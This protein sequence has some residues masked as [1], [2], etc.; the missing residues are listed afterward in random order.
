MSSS[1]D[2]IT[3]L[4]SAQTY[5]YQVGCPILMFIG[6]LGCVLNL[7][8]FTQKNLR[9]NPCSIYFIT[10]NLSNFVYIYSSL[11]SLTLSVGYNIDPSAY[12]LAICH[13]RLYII[14]LFNCLSPFYLILASID[15]I[16]ITSPNARTRRRSTPHFAC[17]C[18]IFGTL[19]WVLFHSHA[20]ILTNITQLGPNYFLC[21]FQSGI[22]LVFIS[23]YSFIKELLAI[24]LMILCGLWS[25]KNIQNTH[26]VR[27]APDLSVSRTGIESNLHSTSSKDR[28][29]MFMLLLDTTIYGLF[30]FMFA[31]FL[32]YQQ[33]T[34]NYIKSAD[35]IQIENIIRN[36]CL[37]GVGVPFCSSCYT[38]LIASKTFRKKVKKVFSWKR[39]FCIN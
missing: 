18:I 13:L 15:R 16:L 9:K 20:L 6:T 35:Q 12:N 24:S 7:I 31:I 5:L 39:I 37:F 17:M 4:T 8:V 21:Y 36:I 2:L 28:Q 3:T 10:Y 27:P 29:L 14:I 26:R 11:L 19:F 34:Q 33:I 38:N 30:S 1:N 22:Y 25:I 32:M 23:Y